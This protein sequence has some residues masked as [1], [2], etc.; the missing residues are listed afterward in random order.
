VTAQR[1]RTTRKVAEA[2]EL[3][4]V[5]RI[6]PCF[7][8]LSKASLDR[9][10]EEMRIRR[11][12]A[13]AIIFREGEPAREFCVVTAGHL[14]LRA[15]GGDVESPPV[16]TIKAPNWFG[17]LAL[18]TGQ[19]RT[20]TVVARSEATIG[21]LSR[22]RFTAVLD[23]HPV[24]ARN[25]LRNLS[26]AI[27]RKDQDFLGQSALAL[28]NARLLNT[29]REQAQ[30]LATVSLRKSQFLANM[31]H[32]VRTPLNAIIGFSDVLLDSTVPVNDED[33]RQFLTD[34]RESG[35]HL[36]HL[37]NEILDLSKIEAGRM[38]LHRAPA[39]LGDIL[40]TV[41]STLR[42]LAAKKGI[43]FQVDRAEAIAPFAMDAL[44]ITQVLMNL[45]G[46]AIKFTPEGGR[47][48]V[49]ATQ[50]NGAV[51]VE[52]GD[53]GPGIAPE[54]HERIFEEFQQIEN[55]HRA[56]AQ[57]GTGLGLALAKRFV[58]MHGGKLWVESAAGKGSRFCLRLPTTG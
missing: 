43:A 19:L 52:V 38:E 29:V 36:L 53:T 24:I 48:W 1:P 3:A 37:I 30:Q 49:H 40:D 2:G 18:L 20:A 50:E 31:S 9:L 33:Q 41:Q 11:F 6:L 4:S 12:A 13:G 23:R 8:G 54:D 35:K 32:E 44:R 56:G 55:S 15:S 10:A 47:V 46:N 51:R 7:A 57:E 5:L 21:F 26:K 17:E 16:G 28:Q 45:V 39:V 22:P 42:S 58:E 34:I 27:Q 14:E 25:L